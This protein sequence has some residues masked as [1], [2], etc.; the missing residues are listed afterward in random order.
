MMKFA[1]EYTDLSQ[2][3]YGGFILRNY[4]PKAKVTTYADVRAFVLGCGNFGDKT[5]Y[6]YFAD[7]NDVKELSYKQFSDNILSIATAMCALRLSGKRVAVIS[8]NRVEWMQAYLGTLCAK[9][10]V[11]PMDRELMPQQ[12]ADFLKH[13]NC[14]AVFVSPDCYENLKDYLTDD[15]IKY[16]FLMSQK[17]CVPFNNGYED[18]AEIKEINFYNLVAY[19]MHLSNAG[20]M[21][22]YNLTYNADDLAV[23]LFTSGTTGTSKGVMLSQKNILVTAAECANDTCFYKDDV[24]LSVLPIHHTYETTIDLA[25]MHLGATICINNS[26]KYVLRNLKRFRPTGLILV[27]LFVQTIHKRIFDEIRKK[28]KLNSFNKAVTITKGLRK[29]KIDLRRPLFSEV[30]SSLGGRLKTIICGGAALDPKLVEDFKDFGINIYQ[31]YGITECSP[32]VSVDL[33]THSKIG[34]VGPA[35]KCCDVKVYK[36]S[37]RGNDEASAGEIGELAVKGDNVMRGYYNDAKATDN[38]FTSE[39]YFLTGDLG[40]VDKDGYIYITGR[41]K[42]LIILANGKNV[43]PEEIEEYLSRI[44]IVN[45]C[46]VV[47]RTNNLN[48]PVITAIVVPTQEVL[49]LESDS[50]IQAR[51]K[52]AILLV[53]KQLPSFK[54]IRNV[55]IRRTEF[56]KTSSKKIKRFV[57]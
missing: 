11:V 16:V 4:F 46:A 18:I 17:D 49:S 45:E 43:Y 42:N 12:T 55:E 5:L 37:A 15:A 7:K 30:I 13:S 1:S 41:K 26:I 39:G 27:P 38:A 20:Y 22:V 56:E 57:L 8:E 47:A 50:E 25:I 34:S 6:K 19:G 29:V 32:L 31:G 2:L 23:L 36:D 21:G 10:V 53:N 35:I 28:G 33:Y 24:F 14:S 48:E 52:E 54:Q 44:D 40:K 3:L 51:V 9:S